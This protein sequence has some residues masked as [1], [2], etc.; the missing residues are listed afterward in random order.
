MVGEAFDKFGK[1]YDPKPED[2]EYCKKFW[3]VTQKLVDEKKLH[4]HPAKV[5]KDGLVGAFDGFQQLRDGKVSG[6]KLVYR[7]EETPK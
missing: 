6:V 7:V 5:G 2:F 1:H 4:P 3:E